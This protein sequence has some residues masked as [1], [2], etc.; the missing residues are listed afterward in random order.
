MSDHGLRVVFAQNETVFTEGEPGERAYLIERGQIDISFEREGK[1]IRIASLGAGEI[2]GE[3][4]LIDDRPRSATARAV[5]ETEAIVIRRDQIQLV[6]KGAD[7]TLALL[8]RVLLGRFRSMQGLLDATADVPPVAT[9]PTTITSDHDVAAIDRLRMEEEIAQAMKRDE[10]DLLLQ[11]I[12]SLSDGGVAG[13]ETLLRWRH[14]QR[15][16]V[17]PNLM[18]QLA[19]SSALIQDLDAWVFGAALTRIRKLHAR[20]DADGGDRPLP[21]VTINLSGMSFAQDPIP[22]ARGFLDMVDASGVPPGLVKIE[23]TEGALIKNPKDVSVALEALRG[24]GVHIALDDFGTGYSSLSYLVGFPITTLKIDR[25]FVQDMLKDQ[26]SLEVVRAVISLAHALNLETIAEGVETTEQLQALWR[27][28]CGY[29]QGYLL[30]RPMGQEQA[31]RL[32][33][34]AAVITRGPVLLEE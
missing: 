15:G 26:R 18:V 34:Q 28:Q 31:G 6:L 20:F 1:P 21:F 24:A 23:I 27:M 8:L 5:A 30:G 11:P 13:F 32:A 19:E 12:V 4:A 16:L 29:G 10:F 17:P 3:M 14:P 7:P 25:M 33:A 2:F 9:D 22:A